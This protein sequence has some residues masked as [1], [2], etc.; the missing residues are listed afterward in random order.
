MLPQ[1]KN[2]RLSGAESLYEPGK[3]VGKS[4]D[5]VGRMLNDDITASDSDVYDKWSQALSSAHD[6][7]YR[8]CADGNERTGD[9]A[10]SLVIPVLVVPDGRLW[11]T[12]F[13]KDGNRTVDPQLTDRCS[14]F[15]GRT[16]YHRTARGD[17]LTLSHLEF[18]TMAGLASFVGDLCGTPDRVEATFPT[19]RILESFQQQHMT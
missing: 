15:V 17:T 1:S 9:F 8:A 5:Q 11:A 4:C 19:E 7:T 12:H 2:V 13:D 16:Y 10:M 6:L 3:P 18:V 14:Y